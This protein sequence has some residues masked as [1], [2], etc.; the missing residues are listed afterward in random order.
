M[1]PAANEVLMTE[2]L[3]PKSISDYLTRSGVNV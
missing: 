2:R 3:K 1:K